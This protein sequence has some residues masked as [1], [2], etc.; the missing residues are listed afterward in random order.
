MP[1]SFNTPLWRTSFWRRFE[2]W[3]LTATLDDI[4]QTETLL[5]A[6]SNVVQ[7]IHAVFANALADA[8]QLQRMPAS[9]VVALGDAHLPSNAGPVASVA[10]TRCD[11]AVSVQRRD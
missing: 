9:L 10:V 11:A 5:A 7:P 6:H 1:Q 4:E 3:M 8:E 2:Q